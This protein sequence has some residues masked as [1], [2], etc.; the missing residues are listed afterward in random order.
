MWNSTDEEKDKF[1]VEPFVSAATQ[2]R[3]GQYSGLLE[4]LTQ[5]IDNGII[6]LL[7]F[8]YCINLVYLGHDIF[9][10]HALL[11]R[12]SLYCLWRQDQASVTDLK[13]VLDVPGLKSEVLINIDLY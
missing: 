10:P 6:Y 1:N 9:K 4:L 7:I 13:A 3:S 12:G 2:F 8:S 11:L 5:S